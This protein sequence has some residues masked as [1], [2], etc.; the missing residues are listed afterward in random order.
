M[1]ISL[2]QALRNFC[3][4]FLS[5]CIVQID[6]MEGLHGAFRVATTHGDHWAKEETA[7]KAAKWPNHG[8]ILR[9]AVL[10]GEFA[11]GDAADITDYATRQARTVLARPH[12][13]G[14]SVS[15]TTWPRARQGISGQ[16]M[17][18]HCWFPRLYGEG[19]VIATRPLLAHVG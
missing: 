14:L 17:V 7:A 16:R 11:R 1:A 4:Y 9:M 12:Q 15:E 2:W 8:G 5:T 13:S 3:R 18:D 10:D 6:F 19:R